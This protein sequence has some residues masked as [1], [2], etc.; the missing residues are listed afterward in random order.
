MGYLLSSYLYYRLGFPLDD[1]W[2]HQ[3]YARNL[4][5]NGEWAFQ[6]GIPSAGSTSPLWSGILGLGYLLG[7][8]PY[9]WTYFLGWVFLFSIS[10]LGFIT[11]R[12]LC[13]NKGNWALW[14]GVFLIF[15]WHMVWA[16]TSGMETLPFTFLIVMVL[17]LLTGGNTN[18]WILGLLI[19]LSVWMRPDGITLA[20]PAFSCAILIPPNWR[21]R[22]LA[23]GKLVLGILLLFILYL[24]FNQSLSGNWWPNTFFAKQAEYAMLQQI[25]FAN[26]WLA[27]ASLPLIG[28]GVLLLPGFL[29][30][31]AC[32]LR[33]RVWGALMSILWVL[34]YLSVYAWR[35][36]VTYQHG[37]YAMP[38]MAVY[39]L[40]SLSGIF[41]WL[42]PFSSFLWKR[43]VGKA[44]LLSFG[45]VL[46]SF[47]FIGAKAYSRD[48]AIIESEMVVTAHW[49]AANTEAD[50]LIA[51]HDI[52][53]IG[54]FSGRRLLDL[55]GLT[56]PDVIPFIGDE[57][58]LRMYLIE[59]RV[60]YLV[61]FPDWYPDLVEQGK[62]VYS[63]N[64]S[65][66]PAM[67]GE[68][69]SVYQWAIH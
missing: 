38:A 53:A 34:G 45:I 11:F 16:A 36:P 60:N 18:W 62:L 56:T 55:A 29:L 24:A 23:V 47:W 66:S 51:A 17:M 26:R 12:K 25:P 35:L 41:C 22:L 9:V 42:E 52:G 14:V 30:F 40:C 10:A 31:M 39:F 33:N 48:V 19:G 46:V 13:P 1:A 21:E 43:V 49:I 6:L 5:I 59:K 68:N 61:T 2:I 54:Y 32:S 64:G 15:E 67:G 4:V 27:Q 69:M 50:A 44:Y 57:E 28:A 65:F 20:A 37:R 63:T 3:T 58:R 8:G 7:L